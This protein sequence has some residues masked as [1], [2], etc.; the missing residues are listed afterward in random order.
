MGWE[1]RTELTEEEKLQTEL[2]TF[3]LKSKL[4]DSVHLIALMA[5]GELVRRGKM[6]SLAIDVA[7]AVIKLVKLSADASQIDF[8][9][10]KLPKHKLS[11]EQFIMG[12]P[13]MRALAGR[14]AGSYGDQLAKLVLLLEDKPNASK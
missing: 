12:L 6:D 8:L 2:D 3:V 7:Q 14:K 11:M 1:N 5:I 10:E 9:I 13:V 4:N